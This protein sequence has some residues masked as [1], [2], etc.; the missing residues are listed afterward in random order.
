[1]R[2]ITVTVGPLAAASANAIALT[3]TPTGALTLNG[4][5]A[6]GGVVTMDQPRQ[7][8][9]TTTADESAKTFKIVGTDWAGNPIG[10]TVAGAN[11]ATSASVL[12]YATVTSITIS[13]TAA[14]ALTVGTNGIAT[15]PWVRMDSFGDPVTALQGVVSGTV[16]YTVQQTL[17]DPNSATNPVS[18]QNVTWLNVP[19]LNLVG[20][21]TSAQSYNSSTPTFFQVLLNSGNGS[22]TLTAV[23]ANG[24]NY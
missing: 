11:N 19:D 17:D 15:S 20:A 10:E 1:M 16:N 4:S 13:S 8:L 21:T 22:V 23:Q 6:T 14:G 7:V 5:L 3:Q 9:I 12:S 2:P 24:G 18:P